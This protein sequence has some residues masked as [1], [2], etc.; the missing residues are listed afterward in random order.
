MSLQPYRDWLGIVSSGKP[1]YYQ[2]FGLRLFVVDADTIERRANSLSARLGAIDAGPHE[3]VRRE[4]LQRIERARA[5]LLDPQGKELYDQQLRAILPQLIKVLDYDLLPVPQAAPP[6]RIAGRAATVSVGDIVA[7]ADRAG[8][9]LPAGNLLEDDELLEVILA[10]ESR[11]GT[12]GPRESPRRPAL[13]AGHRPPAAE[14]AILPTAASAPEPQVSLAEPAASSGDTAKFPVIETSRIPPVD[15]ADELPLAIPLDEEEVTADAALPLPPL[16]LPPLPLVAEAAA[17]GQPPFAGP[18]VHHGIGRERVANPAVTTQGARGSRS[19]MA[20]RL[21]RDRNLTQSYLMLGLLFAIAMGLTGYAGMKIAQLVTKADEG[22]AGNELVKLV[23]D[24]QVGSVPGRGPEAN[25]PASGGLPEQRTGNEQRSRPSADGPDPIEP[26]RSSLTN[27]AS[28]DSDE[29]HSDMGRPDTGRPE[30]GRPETGRP[31]MGRPEMGDP[32]AVALERRS[33]S[34]ALV[35]LTEPQ[36]EEWTQL[37]TAAVLALRRGEIDAA[38]QSLAAAGFVESTTQRAALRRLLV[39]TDH[40][41]QFLRA[42]QEV[43]KKLQP[44]E[45][46]MVGGSPIAVVEASADLLIVRVAGENRRYPPDDL[47]VGLAMAIADR[48]FD[49]QAESTIAFKAAYLA[50]HGRADEAGQLWATA[51]RAGVD[52]GDLPEVLAQ[53]ASVPE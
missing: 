23:R 48:W 36:R 24:A 47:P 31:E 17:A 3:A 20:T 19:A 34:N 12:I 25:R 26:R 49:G 45:E 18:E 50:V 9:N 8:E 10:D 37:S 14:Q 5:T 44:A 16:P 4:L 32:A 27:R 42:V 6:K 39:L 1:T 41:S 33:D 38:R 51:A 7:D 13:I 11:V 52:L 35:E 15:S 21:K 40:L 43:I 22:V 29:G 2:L 28:D 46:I 53:L 30:T